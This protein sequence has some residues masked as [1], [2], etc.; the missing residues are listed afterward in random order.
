MITN[1]GI[2]ANPEKVQAIIDLA[3]LKSLRDVQALNGKLAAQGRFLSKYAERSLILFKTLKGCINKKDFRWSTK[4]ESSLQELKNHLKSL[5]ALR[6]PKPE[7][8]LTLY[9]AAANEAISAVLSTKRRGVEKQIYFISCALQGPEINYPSLE[10]VALALVLDD[11]KN[12]QLSLVSMKS[13]TNHASL[14]K[15]K[16]LWI[17]LQNRQEL[18][19]D[20]LSVEGSGARL[21]LT[22]PN[23]QEVTYALRFDFKTSNNEVE[24]EALIAG[25]ELVVQMGVQHLQVFSY[26]ILITN[27]VKGIYEA[28]EE[29]MIRC[30]KQVSFVLLSTPH[31]EGPEEAEYV[32]KE[33]HFGSCRAHAGARTIAQKAARLGHYWPIMYNDASKLVEAC[34]AC[35]Q[36]APTIR[37]P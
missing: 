35:Q 25:L 19:S 37:Q 14:L 26:S 2:K 17:F 21:I 1:E 5:S 6:I 31:E 8:T 16:Y 34:Q 24:Y 36:H 9:L 28:K 3:S 29:L 22:D 15:D 30:L 20:A 12:R 4:A 10:K 13:Y 23:G 11:W 7:E 33:A 27:Q 32:L 18:K